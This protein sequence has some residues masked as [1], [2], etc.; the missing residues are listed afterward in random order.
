MFAD[1]TPGTVLVFVSS[2]YDFEGD[3][4]A[5]LE[6]VEKFYSCI[7]EIVEFRPYTVESARRLAQELAKRGGIAIGL[8]EL[9]LLVDSLAGD[10]SRISMKS[11]S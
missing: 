8:A 1:P 4:R 10:P 3:D 9:G 2:R 11:K 7:P 5:K 6:R